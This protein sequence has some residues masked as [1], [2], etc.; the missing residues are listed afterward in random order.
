MTRRTSLPAAVVWTVWIIMTAALLACVC[1][2]TFN[3]PLAEDWHLVPPMTGH[4]AH[5]W[6]WLWEQNNEHRLP[7]PRLVLLAVLTPT[8][9]FRWGMAANITLMSTVVFAILWTL[10]RRRGGR[11]RYTDAFVPIALL[12]IGN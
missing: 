7:L 6:T 11:L 12:H 1:A 4:Q 2:Y 3:M 9:D 5:L 8:H 10:A